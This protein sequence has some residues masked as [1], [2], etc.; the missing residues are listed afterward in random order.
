MRIVGTPEHTK[1]KNYIKKSLEDL[2]WTVEI[3]SFKDDTPIFGSL[4]FKNVI[5]KLNPN[6][7]R[8]LALACHYDSKYTKERNFIGA[9][10]SAV[11]CAQMINLA[12]VM[13]NYLESIKDNDISL[14]F[15][16]FDGEEAFKE[17]GPKD[18]IYGAKH[19]AKIWHNNYTIFRNGENI[20]ELDKL[21]QHFII[22]LAIQKNG[23]LY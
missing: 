23:I 14:M 22:T 6:A 4:E 7:K 11:P 21:I 19:L 18:S 10:D 16:F 20:S 17:W 5:A 9:T 13:K 1:V 2:N 12:K 15:I 3:D 8:Y